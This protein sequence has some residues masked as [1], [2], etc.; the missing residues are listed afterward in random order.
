MMMLATAVLMSA[1]DRLWTKLTGG[2]TTAANLL[3]MSTNDR[4]MASDSFVVFTF[5]TVTLVHCILTV[6]FLLL[7]LS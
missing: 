4:D 5:F 7:V 1:S 3:S 2:S 6:Q